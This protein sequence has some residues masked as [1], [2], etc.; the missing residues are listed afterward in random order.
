MKT[1]APTA[2]TATARWGALFALCLSGLVIGFDATILNVALPTLARDLG[3][4]TGQQ[5]WIV[6]A[7]LVAFAAAMLPAGLFGDRLG[8]KRTLV[9]GLALFALGS[10]AGALVHSPGPLIAARAAMGLG[11]AVVFPLMLSA[12]PTLFPV[13]RERSRAVGIVTVGFA[14]GL[15]VGPLL[16]GLLLNHFWWGSIFVLNLCTLA[17][18]LVAIALLLPES[19]D[20]DA[21]RVRP[22]AALLAAAGL[23]GIVFG[24]IE[25]PQH[26]WGDARTLGPLVAGLALL[27][28]FLLTDRRSTHP[29][30]PLAL[31]RNRGYTWGMVAGVLVSFLMSGTLFLLPLYLQAV[32]GNDAF[33]TGVRLLPMMGGLLVSGL[34]CDRIVPRTG[35]RWVVAFGLAGATVGALLGART[36][37]SDGYAPTALWLAVLGAGIGFAMIPSLDAALAALPPQRA[38]AGSSVFQTLRQVGGALGVA[39]LGSL[40]TTRFTAALDVRGLTPAAART[41]RASVVAS[42]RIGAALHRP[43]LIA[44]GHAAF[45]SGMT[46]VLAVCG[47]V[48]AATMLAVLVFMPSALGRSPRPDHNGDHEQREQQQPSDVGAS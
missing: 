22:F 3:A 32:L 14:L 11:G 25:A 10:L 21:P 27:A 38:G 47:A 7:Y 48:S 42:D 30:V 28:A 26:G 45:V 31:F 1:T 5:Q 46:T 4:D 39:L 41:A 15:P 6:D 33:G 44:S 13:D 20:P 18:A 34:L 43:D 17:V 2:P 9:A 29:M 40:L 37:A 16:G 19:R 24:I 35:A 8:R 12:L 23:V 36:S